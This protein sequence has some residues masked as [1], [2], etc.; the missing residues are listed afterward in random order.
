MKLPHYILFLCLLLFVLMYETTCAGGYVLTGTVTDYSFPR[1]G[2]T[3]SYQKSVRYQDASW[4][5]YNWSPE[6]KRSPKSSEEI[7]VYGKAQ[8]AIQAYEVTGFLLGI[9]AS[10]FVP[11]YEWNGEVNILKEN[12]TITI[13]AKA[14]FASNDRTVHFYSIICGDAI[15]T[16]QDVIARY[17]LIEKTPYRFALCSLP[18]T[19]YTVY[20]TTW[21]E[22]RP[23]GKP[24]N[25]AAGSV[26]PNSLLDLVTL[27]PQVFQI[28][29]SENNLV[30]EYSNSKT[31]VYDNVPESD[32][33]LLFGCVGMLH[34]IVN[35]ANNSAG[36]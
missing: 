28:L 21:K 32:I 20:I 13:P 17:T 8:R 2:L 19:D 34:L 33:D 5:L 11:Q 31:T 3:P 23:I 36:I 1:K 14:V 9:S 10:S 18:G 30:A 6:K 27:R 24:E 7:I 35:I 25:M 12:N 26:P 4:G 29:D 22:F 15:V 16:V